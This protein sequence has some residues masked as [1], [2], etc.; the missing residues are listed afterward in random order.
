M[1]VY[2]IFNWWMQLAGYDK[3]TDFY[4]YESAENFNWQN[5]DFAYSSLKTVVDYW[6]SLFGDITIQTTDDSGI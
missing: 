5:K 6:K 4:K 3:V 2:T 1:I